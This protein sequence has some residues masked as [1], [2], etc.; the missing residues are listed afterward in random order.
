[1]TPTIMDRFLSVLCD[2]E[3]DMTRTNDLKGVDVFRILENFID[4]ILTFST[5]LLSKKQFQQF[6]LVLEDYV[7]SKYSSQ[8]KYSEENKHLKKRKAFVNRVHK[9]EWIKQLKRVVESVR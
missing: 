9:K 1:M 8:P 5:D 3:K 7:G 2:T 6:L 4:E